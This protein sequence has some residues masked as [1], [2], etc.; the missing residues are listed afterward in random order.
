MGNFTVNGKIVQ[1]EDEKRLINFL[2]FNLHLTSVKDGCSEGACGACTILVDGEPVRACTLLTTEV[3]GKTVTTLEGLS[4]SEKKIFTYAFGE[5]GAVQCGYCTPGMIICAKGLLDKNPSPTEKE[6]RHAIRNNICRCTGYVKIVKAIEMAA[7]L[8]RQEKSDRELKDSRNWLVGERVHR[9]DVLDKTTGRAIYPDDMYDDNQLNLVAVRS[10]HPRARVL[11][12]DTSIAMNV[13]GVYS[14]YTAADV[15]GNKKVG[16]IKKDWDA[17]IAVGETT[18]YIGDVIALV[19]A[20]T[21]SAAMKARDLVKVEYEVLPFVSSPQEAMKEGAP[22][23][24]EEGNLLGETHVDRGDVEK[25]LSESDYVISGHFETPWTEHAFIETECAFAYPLEN[26]GVKIYSTDQG[27]YDTRR[28]TAPFLGLSEDLVVVENCYVGGGFGGKE[29]VTVQHLSALG[30]LLTGRPCKMKLTRQ[31]SINVHPKRHPMSIDMTMGCTKDGIIKG[32]KA[33]LVTDTGAYASLGVPVLQRACTHAAGPYNYQNFKIDGYAWY[34][35]NPPAGA[36]RGFGVTQSCF[37]VESMI[38]RLADKVGISHWEMRYRNAIRPGQELPNGQI[39]DQYTGLA[40]TLEAVKDEFYANSHVG[41]ACAMKNAGVGVGLPDYGRVDLEVKDGKVIIHCGGSCLGQGLCTVLKQMVCQASGLNG[42]LVE[43]ERSRSDRAPDSG[44]SSGSR[45]TT[46]SGE[47]ARRAG[48]KLKEALDRGETLE[49]LE[50][51]HFFAEYLAKTDPFGSDLPHPKSHVAYGF[52]T[53]MCI[54]DPKTHKVEKLI[55]AHDVGRAI[56]PTNVEGQIEGGVV[57]GLGYALRERYTLKNCIPQ[58][59][60]G[61]LGLFRADELP[62]IK[63]VIVE[64]EGLDTSFGGIG[65]GEITSIPTAP[66]VA[67]AYEQLDGEERSSLPVSNTPYIPLESQA[68]SRK[69]RVLTADRNKRCISCKE[70]MRACSTTYF[71]SEKSSLAYLQVR[72]RKGIGNESGISGEITRPVTCIQCGAC[73]RACKKG[74]I[75]R[76]RFGVYVV[77]IKMCNGCGDCKDACPLDLIVINNGTATKCIACGK[78][79][80]ACPTG[81]LRIES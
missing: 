41:I 5:A 25:A 69:S 1:I 44:T 28:E 13:P 35:N 75:N 40:E 68:V 37:A 47:A 24:H 53:Q 45:H 16:H 56:N 71:K 51:Q 62:E 64:K 33:K 80:K 4:D 8:F 14:I 27:V 9:V 20:E 3:E 11:S 42:N 12:I 17:F 39:A 60:F 29:D 31:E 79:V 6:I 76:N 23:V 61:S 36:F 57:M 46:V 67:D 34:T 52:A 59:K 73:A 50:G 49:S 77:D 58:D 43:E 66:A 55:A 81:V 32:L 21:R 26:G 18:R 10:K 22:L 54:L 70:C 63:A 38:N 2:R 19:A 78:C 72:A 15:P 30:A 48:V 7:E 74:A 65:L